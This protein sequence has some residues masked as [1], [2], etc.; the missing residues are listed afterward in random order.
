MNTKT[1]RVGLLLAAVSCNLSAIDLR[2]AE[3]IALETAPGLAAIDAERSATLERAEAAAVLP[4]PRLRLAALA[5]PVDTFDLDQEPM[6]QLQVGLV[7]QFP[8]GK[9]LEL[10]RSQLLEESA[11]TG[12]ALRDARRDVK[13]AV[14]RAWIDG[15]LQRR[16]RRVLEESREVLADLRGLTADYYATGRARQQDVH[17]TDLELARL[18]E[19]ILQ[20]RQAEEAARARL[21]GW[22]GRM[23]E[24]V[25]SAEWPELNLSGSPPA[26]DHPRI[27]AADRTIAVAETGVAIAREQYK[28]GF[29]I[30]VSYG[31]RSGQGVTGAARP[32]FLSAMVMVDLPI[33]RDRR[34]DRELAAAERS[35]EAARHERE[36]TLR[37]LRAAWEEKRAEYDRV[38]ERL[39][40]FEERLLPEAEENS[41]VALDAFRV[42]VGDMTALMRAQLTEFDV[43][44]EA[45]RT[46]AE[47]LQL[48]AELAWL[49]GDRS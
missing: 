28:P 27:A 42:S 41:A 46:R 12:E 33:F 24:Q 8:R 23:A 11:R 26:L 15:V 16:V 18:D 49:E 19:R 47:W 37:L 45:E 25:T 5:L 30:D 9:T 14:R 35:A 6:T 22:I 13:L 17:R 10:R 29:S 32:D 20:S 2:D 48:R 39:G 38:T 3:R 4:D 21:T 44:I 31:D 34:Q 43:R 40:L 1:M 36:D 7:Q